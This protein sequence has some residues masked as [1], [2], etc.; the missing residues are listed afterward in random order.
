M[1]LVNSYSIRASRHGSRSPGGQPLGARCSGGRGRGAAVRRLAW[2][3][4]LCLALGVALLAAPAAAQVNVETLRSS[5][6]EEGVGGRAKVSVTTNSGN[7]RGISLGGSLLF[8]VS[9]G[10]HL[11]YL[12]ASGVY[13]RLGGSV[14]AANSFVHARYNYR[15]VERVWAEVF[16]QA[17]A[18]RF[19]RLTLRQVS[20]IGPRVAVVQAE[21]MALFVGALHL[22]EYNRLQAG[23]VPVRPDWVHRLGSYASFVGTYEAAHATLTTTLYYQP[24]YA[25]P[26]DWRMLWVS[27]LEFSINELLTAGLSATLRHESPVA[28]GLKKRDLTFVNTLGLTL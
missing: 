1:T 21:S 12:S 9:S 10:R 8:G 23:E 13:T 16:A 3:L 15:L 6:A 28:D 7:T 19:R 18:D 27:A 20:G 4:A 25:D 5:L 2:G 14:D 26:D 17:E 11:G 22:V 24:R